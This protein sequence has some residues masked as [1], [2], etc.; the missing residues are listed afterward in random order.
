MTLIVKLNYLESVVCTL[1]TNVE[2]CCVSPGNIKYP[3]NF[4]EF[5]A[6]SQGDS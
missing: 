6:V 4:G 5:T 1:L 2:H 3:W